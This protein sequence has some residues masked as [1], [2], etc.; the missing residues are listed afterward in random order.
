[1][2]QFHAFSDGNSLKDH[3]NTV[4][5]IMFVCIFVLN[6]RLAIDAYNEAKQINSDKQ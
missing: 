5:L 1:V 3:D 4:F 6:T 2:E